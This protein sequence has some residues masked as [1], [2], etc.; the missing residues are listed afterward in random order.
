VGL[1]VHGA[2]VPPAI[3][4]AKVR[5]PPLVYDPFVCPHR[6]SSM[7]PGAPLARLS[8]LRV[9]PEAAVPSASPL[10]QPAPDPVPPGGDHEN[11][12]A[13]CLEKKDQKGRHRRRQD[14]TLLSTRSSILCIE[15]S[16]F[17]GPA[18]MGVQGGERVHFLSRRRTVCAAGVVFVGATLLPTYAASLLP[19]GRMRIWVYT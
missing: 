4:G 12:E 17:P 16:G 5:P 8:Y 2:D 10:P 9:P 6:S 7:P 14:A 1:P 18:P 3:S 11:L 13:V 19:G 15:P